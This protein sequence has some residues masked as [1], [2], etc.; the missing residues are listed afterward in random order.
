MI[1]LLVEAH[2]HYRHDW[3][4][5]TRLSKAIMP[6]GLAIKAVSTPAQRQHMRSILACEYFRR[7]HVIEMKN[8]LLRAAKYTR[9]HIADSFEFIRA[10]EIAAAEELEEAIKSYWH[11]FEAESV[12]K[13]P[14]N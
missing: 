5:V 13:I 14:T 2:I 8:M 7:R 9:A 11:A 4:E 1:K 12:E 3:E 10:T 6:L